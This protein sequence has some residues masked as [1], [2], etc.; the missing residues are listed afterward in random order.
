M[1]HTNGTAVSYPGAG[2]L[3]LSTWRIEGQYL[4]IGP[5]VSDRLGQALSIAEKP[6]AAITG[7]RIDHGNGENEY[8]IIEVSESAI[9][10]RDTAEG[11]VV[12][13]TRIPE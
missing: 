1:F 7:Y 12:R 9:Q 5:K 3:L 8:E 11:Q 13:L 6:L 10:L 4:M 2:D